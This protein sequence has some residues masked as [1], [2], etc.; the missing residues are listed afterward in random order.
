MV[1]FQLAKG[2]LKRMN[3]TENVDKVVIVKISYFYL[4]DRWT[5]FLEPQATILGP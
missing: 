4:W 5:I 1:Y 3:Y 2:N